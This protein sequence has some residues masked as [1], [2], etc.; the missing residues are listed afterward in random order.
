MHSRKARIASTRIRTEAAAHAGWA[1]R[2]RSYFRRTAKAPSSGTSVI[3]V[4]VAGL[5]IFMRG[6]VAGLGNKVVEDRRVVDEGA[7]GPIVELRMPLHGEHVRR[8]GPANGLDDAVGLRPGLD[9]ELPPEILHRLMVHRV[10]LDERDSG[11]EAREPRARDQR[12]GMAVPVVDVPV[13]V[14]QRPR[15]LQRDVLVESPALRH[16]D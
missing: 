14:I 8:T 1:A 13:A 7:I 16:I 6:S 3:M 4:P 10:R 12:G 5:K 2:A 9:D 15:N 11:V